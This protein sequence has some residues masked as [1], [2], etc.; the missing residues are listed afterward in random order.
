[1]LSLGK[2]R[3]F[4]VWDE[5]RWN[6]RFDSML[7][8]KAY[9]KENWKISRN[10]FIHSIICRS[11]MELH[12]SRQFPLYMFLGNEKNESYVEVVRFMNWSHYNLLLG[13][14]LVLQ[15]SEESS[16]L[17]FNILTLLRK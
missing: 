3:C 8:A 1:M 11:W 12:G 15:C 10:Q 4:G 13:D 6:M 7:C 2:L 16:W 14:I 9:P 5:G 17:D